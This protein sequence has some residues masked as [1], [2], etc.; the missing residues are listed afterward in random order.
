MQTMC[1]LN[2]EHSNMAEGGEVPLTNRQIQ[3]LGAAISQ[4]DME[5]FARGYLNFNNATLKNMKKDKTSEAFNREV[6]DH[7]KN[8]NP[9]DQVMVG[10][11]FLWHAIVFSFILFY[12]HRRLTIGTQGFM[13]LM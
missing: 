2:I 4:D 12:F 1:T 8:K 13:T 3:R 7:W 6:I 10:K 9:K 11:T 5:T